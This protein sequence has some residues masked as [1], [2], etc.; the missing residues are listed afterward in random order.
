MRFKAWRGLSETYRRAVEGHSPWTPDERNPRP[1]HISDVAA[2]D[3]D[4]KLADVKSARLK[5]FALSNRAH[6]KYRLRRGRFP[7]FRHFDGC[8]ISGIEGVAKP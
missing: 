8:V 2:A 4:V 6:D 1:I 7:F 3:L 5:C